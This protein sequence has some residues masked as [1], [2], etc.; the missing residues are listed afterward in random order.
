M[1]YNTAQK[2]VTFFRLPVLRHESNIYPLERCSDQSIFE[3]YSGSKYHS[4]ML[5]HAVVEISRVIY[6]FASERK[7]ETSEWFQTQAFAHQ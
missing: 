7:A 6:T 2:P 4:H 3:S 5:D 1:F